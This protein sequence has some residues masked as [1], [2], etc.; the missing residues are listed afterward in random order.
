MVFTAL[1]SFTAAFSL[2]FLIQHYD[3]S[4]KSMGFYFAVGLL[5]TALTVTERRY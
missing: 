1:K 3:P 4:P 2:G 5:C